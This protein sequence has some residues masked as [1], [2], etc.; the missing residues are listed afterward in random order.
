MSNT[1]LGERCKTNTNID[2][3]TFVGIKAN[4]DNLYV[5]FPL[6]Y[7]L[8]DDEKGLRKDIL[9]LLSVLSKN[10]DKKDSKLNTNISVGNVKFP[11]QAYLYVIADFYTRGY[12][13]ERETVYNVSKRGKINWSRTIKT[14][15]TFIQDNNVYYLD[16]VT[17]KQNINENELITLIHKSCV[18]ESFLKIG[19]I[20][21][22]FM[23]EKPIISIE[24]HKN[25]YSSVIKKKMSETFNDRN[26]QLFKN[27]LAIIKS[28]GDNGETNKFEYGTYRFE[29]VWESMI[30]KA[31]GIKNKEKYFPKT[32]WVIDGQKY[33]NSYLEPDTI[34]ISKGN[35]YV[36]DAKYY[37]FGWSGNPKHLPDSS[38]INKQITYGEYI[39]ESDKFKNK[40]GKNPNVFNAF[41]MPYD[42]YGKV[43]HTE[44]NMHYVGS[45]FS[46]WKVQAS[47]KS[48]EEV[49][50]ILIDVKSLM[51][52]YYPSKDKIIKLAEEIERN[53]DKNEL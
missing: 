48:Y 31:Y 10:T 7:R 17:K 45:A 18:Y 23:P 8:S 25:Y 39:A 38:S 24:K 15:K 34:M 46:D 27:M 43:F 14:Q 50:G 21:S 47:T 29:Y 37:K 53:I 11:L 9:L 51:E 36:L 2:T 1:D 44:K 35:V 40:N 13:R 5:S 52:D 12:Y 26:R 42:S 30:D 20:F 4:G 49:V 16:Y 41:I 22:A 33:M 3:D 28:L 6:G 32:N 19:W